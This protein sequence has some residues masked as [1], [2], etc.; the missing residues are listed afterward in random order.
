MKNSILSVSRYPTENLD[1]SCLSLQS[2]NLNNPELIELK[3]IIAHELIETVFQPVVCLN[4]GKVIAYEALSRGPKGSLF[5]F[6]KKM[7]EAAKKYNLL[8]ELEYLCRTASIKNSR[9]ITKTHL[10]FL[11]VDPSTLQH[12][13]SP[14]GVTK[15]FLKS[16]NIPLKKIV[17][18]IT[19]KSAIADYNSFRKIVDYYRKQG[20]NIAV[21]DAGAGYSGLQMMVEIRPQW[22]KLDMSLIRNIDKNQ[23]KKLF[24]KHFYQFALTANIAVV[25]EGVESLDELNELIDIGIPYAQGYYLSKPASAFTEICPEL[26]S[27]LN[28]KNK[29]NSYY[30]K[31]SP[32]V[33]TV[34]EIVRFDKSIKKSTLG[35]ST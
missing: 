20:Y 33:A 23:Y 17:L 3:R 12:S 30:F 18:E 31:N 29:E 24:V 15:S 8:N 4:T 19:E 7:F 6:P 13:I 10:L 25:A 14:K 16:E 28:K 27:L 32:S 34:G 22:I 2:S 9:G 26:S 1:S 11:N 35:E 21:D 5:E